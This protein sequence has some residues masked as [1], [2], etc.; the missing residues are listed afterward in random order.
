MSNDFLNLNRESEKKGPDRSLIHSYGYLANM[1]REI[2]NMNPR[3]HVSGDEHMVKGIEIDP[4]ANN[5]STMSLKQHTA[6]CESFHNP[7]F[8]RF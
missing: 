5:L 7:A 3:L 6:Y 4:G 1:E 2:G 8:R